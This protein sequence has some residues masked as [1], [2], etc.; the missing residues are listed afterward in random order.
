MKIIL[1]VIAAAAISVTAI[2]QE[3]AKQPET[4]APV[5]IEQEQQ[6]VVEPATNEQQ[7]EKK[8]T[9]KFEQLDR[10]ADGRIS[11][12]E[13]KDQPELIRQFSR[14]DLDRSGYLTR[15][16]LERIQATEG[17]QVSMT[18]SSLQYI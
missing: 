9:A 7:E 2:A 3:V 13:A 10:N 17:F 5:K 1:P 15:P 12:I 16:E 8:D 18:R 4:E 14:L 6:P 11:L